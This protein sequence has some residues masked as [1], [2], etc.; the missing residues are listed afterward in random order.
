MIRTVRG[1]KN[2]G[3]TRNRALRRQQAAFVA[4]IQIARDLTALVQVNSSRTSK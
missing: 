2:S 1:Q 4:T 3:K